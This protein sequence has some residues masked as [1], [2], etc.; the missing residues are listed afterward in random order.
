MSHK[1]I[2]LKTF[3][4]VYKIS[5]YNYT[6]NGQGETNINNAFNLQG[7]TIKPHT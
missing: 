5:S 2:G 3:K 7:R 1:T 6:A 4:Q